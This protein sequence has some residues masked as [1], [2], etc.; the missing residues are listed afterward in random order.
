[1]LCRDPPPHDVGKVGRDV[2]ERL[3]SNERLVRRCQ[4]R[5]ARS[6]A[7]AEDADPIVP[8]RGKPGNRTPRVEHCLA[9]HLHGSRDVGADN[10]VRAVQLGRHAPIV[11]GQAEAQRAQAAPREQPAQA[12]VAAGTGIP[13]RQHQ[14]SRTMAA[15]GRARRGNVAAVD[16]VVFGLRRRERA[17]KRQ[18]LVAVARRRYQFIFVGRGRREE[19]F[20]VGHHMRHPFFEH[21]RRR[22]VWPLAAT[23]SRPIAVLTDPFE[24]PFKRT[25]DPIGGDRREPA[26]PGVKELLEHRLLHHAILTHLIGFKPD[27]KNTMRFLTNGRKWSWPKRAG[28]VGGIALER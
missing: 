4:Q 9:A 12:D 7:G 16:G 24:T 22:D 10:V 25:D 19:R 21:L 26:L 11:I 13:L 6:E 2:I 20:G 28:R 27:V 18:D 15:A 17:R 14:D 3:G 23:R 8:L 5:E 1:M